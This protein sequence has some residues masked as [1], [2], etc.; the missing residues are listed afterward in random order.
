MDL[1]IWLQSEFAS[2]Q[3]IVFALFALALVVSS[4]G[5][6]RT[7]YFISIGYTFS[8]TA[9]IVVTVIAF[10]ANLTW[11]TVLQNGILLIWSVRLGWFVL[12]RERTPS[13]IAQQKEMND[14]INRLPMAVKVAIWISVSL[15]YVAMFSP[16]LFALT[17]PQNAP[18]SVGRI[19]Q[20]LGVAVLGG[21]LLLESLAD[22]QKAAFKTTNPKRFCD[23]GLYS[24]VRCPNYLG[25]IV[26]WIG[27]W[28]IGATFFTTLI[29]WVIS[30]IGLACLVLIMVGSTKRLERTQN[31]RY[32]A[33]EEYQ[34]YIRKVPVLFPFVPVYSLQSV[35]VAI[36]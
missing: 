12:Q 8:I 32:S 23:V 34:A 7:V 17:A 35:R 13:Y 33:S 6:I 15:L 16:S 3:P 19:F 30:F 31:A 14:R 36:E 9:M 11:I 10:A 21:G 20:I 2:V 22:R 26:V 18:S 4:L 27:F 28:M 1:S 24:W 25:E 5:F 29:Q